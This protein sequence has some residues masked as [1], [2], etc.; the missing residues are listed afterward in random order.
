MGRARRPALDGFLRFRRGAHRARPATV[1]PM[2]PERNTMRISATLASVVGAGVGLVAAGATYAAASQPADTS[3]VS[4]T[5]PQAVTT[6]VSPATTGST[7]TDRAVL[8]NGVCVVTI[9]RTTT[10]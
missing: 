3:P 4:S 1:V 5:A 6:T 9:D 10:V 8:K 7:C 2:S